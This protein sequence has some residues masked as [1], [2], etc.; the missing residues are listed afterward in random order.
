MLIPSPAR[1]ATTPRPPVF[2]H[3]GWRCSSTYVWGR[4][5]ALAGVRAYYEPW[6][7]QLAELTPARIAKATPER[8]GLRHPGDGK[9][10]LAEF[11]DLLAEDGGV[12]GY[13]RRFALD[14]YFLDPDQEDPEQQAYIDTLG[15]A[16]HA[17]GERPILAC[18][19]TLGRIGWLK[20]RFDGF[21]IVLIRDPVQ[22]WLSFY[23]LRRR[24]RP[25]YFE[26]CQ[27]VILSEL[28]G[29]E[30]AAARL[31]DGFTPTGGA[32]SKRIAQARRRLKRASPQRSFAAF[33]AVYL[34]SYL[35]ALPEA[36]LV[37]DV[38]RLAWDEDYVRRTEAA[39]EA[40]CGLRPDFSDCRAPAPHPADLVAWGKTAARV[41]AALRLGPRLVEPGWPTIVRAKLW[42][43]GARALAA[44]RSASQAKPAWRSPLTLSAAG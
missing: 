41:V 17:R 35:R 16:A 29:H 5:R 12:A 36:D 30:T 13:R 24:P 22:Q 19:R 6:H 23:S 34:L 11:A 8:S 32:L 18:C 4:F 25:T 39:I 9:P 44:S 20:R 10:Y 7:E 14:A 1:V 33:L 31:L 38:D 3:S 37:I 28:S 2:I 43:G 26:L 21:H 27:Y 40:G 42:T 15:W